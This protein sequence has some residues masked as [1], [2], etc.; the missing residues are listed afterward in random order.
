MQKEGSQHEMMGPGGAMEWVGGSGTSL[1]PGGAQGAADLLV[2]FK[3]Y[4]DNITSLAAYR[5]LF[6]LLTSISVCQTY[7]TI[8]KYFSISLFIR[9]RDAKL[10]LP[11]S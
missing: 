8:Y 10:D 9:E 11:W 1:A 2:R 7:I 3:L 5:P 6:T 4:I